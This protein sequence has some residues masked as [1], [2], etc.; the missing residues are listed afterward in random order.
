MV[1]SSR[2]KSRGDIH[3][4]RRLWHVIGVL[5]IVIGY[6]FL[7]YQWALGLI[8]ALSIFSLVLDIARQRCERLN[9]VVVKV[10]GPLMREHECKGLTGATYIFIGA[11]L[12]IAVFPAPVA[13]LALLFLGLGDPVS[14]Y[15]GIRYGRDRILGRKTLQGTLAGFVTCTAVALIFYSSNNTM[16]EYL[17]TISLISGFAGAISELVPVGSM[18]DNITQPVLSASMLYLIFRFFDG[19]M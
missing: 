14:S 5:V 8:V 11:F 18:D 16:T 10:F 13:T 17:V 3:L 4:A 19:V 2:L 9:Y 1:V 6:Q 15:I 12:V 7:P